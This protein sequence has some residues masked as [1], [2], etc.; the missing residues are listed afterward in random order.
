MPQKT[1]TATLATRH[2]SPWRSPLSGTRQSS[3][4]TKASLSRSWRAMRM[5]AVGPVA[6][7]ALPTT[8]P[9]H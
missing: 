6:S 4:C 7:S 8:S 5:R 9:T 1:P 3:L 2:W